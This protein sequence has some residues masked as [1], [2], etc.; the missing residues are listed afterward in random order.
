[1][2]ARNL[3]GKRVKLT[4]I[5]NDMKQV[6][7]ST[8]LSVDYNIEISQKALSRLERGVRPV[9]DMELVALAKL[10]DITTSWL[11]F[12]EKGELGG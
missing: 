10:L 4:R 8:A 12:G 5:E 7:L 2:K 6:D 11:I 3:C 1:M 9:N